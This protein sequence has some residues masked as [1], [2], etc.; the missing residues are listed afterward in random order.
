M[1]E[2]VQKIYGLLGHPVLHSLSPLMHNAA[3]SHLKINAQYKLFDVLPQELDRFL[4]GLGDEVCGLNVTVPYKEKVLGAVSLDKDTAY[5]KKINAVNTMVRQGSGWRGF[6]T[7]IPGFAKHLAENFDPKGKKAA[8]LGAGGAA[9]AVAYALAGAGAKEIALFDVDAVKSAAVVEMV[10][11]IFPGYDV[12][13]VDS[14]DKLG[15]KDKDLL[16]NATPVGLKDS[17]PCVIRQES[18]HSGLFV[19]DLIYSPAETK[20]LKAA[21]DKGARA[22]N[23]LGMLLYQGA[24]SFEYFTGRPAPVEVMREALQKGVK[25]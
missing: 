9:R 17:D 13:A 8:I 5:L 4:A 2:T 1:S 7:D 14:A 18:I 11:S 21:R 6:N 23:G 10:K 3:L 25:P 20:L 15:L 24:M 16:V 19:Y 22:S 12:S